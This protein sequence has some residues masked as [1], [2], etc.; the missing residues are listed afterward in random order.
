MHLVPPAHHQTDPAKLPGQWVNHDMMDDMAEHARETC[1]FCGIV[2]A[3]PCDSPPPTVCATLSE[4]ML[5]EQSTA[6]KYKPTHGG[7]P[8]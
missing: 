7:Y 6:A 1:R 5:K 4:H 3:T 8:G 2:T